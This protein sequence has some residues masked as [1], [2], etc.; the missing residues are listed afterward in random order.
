MPDSLALK[1]NTQTPPAD[2]AEVTPPVPPPQSVLVPL[3]GFTNAD[4]A[5]E[6]A[7]APRD[8]PR[9]GTR[10]ALV[11]RDLDARARV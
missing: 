7:N 5:A 10:D 2:A 6:A 11:A 8:R 4:G 1:G 9:Q 3:G